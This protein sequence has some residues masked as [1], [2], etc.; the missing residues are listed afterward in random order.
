MENA[1]LGSEEDLATENKVRPLHIVVIIT[2]DNGTTD[3]IG[4]DI[5]E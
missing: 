1:G 3:C 2:A 4:F 5:R